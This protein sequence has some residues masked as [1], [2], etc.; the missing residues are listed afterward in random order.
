MITSRQVQEVLLS[1][2]PRG[3]WMKAKDI[4]ALIESHLPLSAEDNVLIAGKGKSTRWHRVVRNTLQRLKTT[5]EI[6]W[7]RG[8]G[9]RF[10]APT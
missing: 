2:A 3:Q 5:G 4:Y 10:G 7:Q 1:K 8:Q 9:F 6:E